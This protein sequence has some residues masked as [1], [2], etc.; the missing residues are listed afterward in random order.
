MM[1]AYCFRDGHVHLTADAVPEGAVE[2]FRGPQRDVMRLI[3]ETTENRQIL[4]LRDTTTVGDDQQQLL[5]YLQSVEDNAS[6]LVKV[7]DL[8]QD[9]LEADA[10]VA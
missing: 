4:G 9:I 10:E 8:T 2:L 6:R 7:N 5:I 3:D 1:I